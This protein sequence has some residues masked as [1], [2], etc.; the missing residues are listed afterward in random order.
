MGLFARSWAQ[1]SKLFVVFALG[2]VVGASLVWGE[3]LLVKKWEESRYYSFTI[4]I[5]VQLFDNKVTPEY[6]QTIMDEFKDSLTWAMAHA[7]SLKH[8]ENVDMLL[9]MFHYFK[10]SDQE[11]YEWQL[12]RRGETPPKRPR[13][14]PL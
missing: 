10:K 1:S 4:S 2:I 12:K 8:A 14:V 11:W 3:L 13:L 7:Q 9:N 6:I 5:A